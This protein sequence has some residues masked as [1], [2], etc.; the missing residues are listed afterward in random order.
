MIIYLGIDW[1][2]PGPPFGLEAPKG[3]L[4]RMGLHIDMVLNDLG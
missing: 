3:A 1:W 4:T 2:I